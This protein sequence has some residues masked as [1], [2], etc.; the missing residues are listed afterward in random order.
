MLKQHYS[1]GGTELNASATVH[2]NKEDPRET[3]V[4]HEAHAPREVLVTGRTLGQRD[5]VGTLN[6]TPVPLSTLTGRIHGLQTV[7]HEAHAPTLWPLI[8]VSPRQP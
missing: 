8:A 3:T 6:S 2:P 4:E 7:E 5:T 1:Q